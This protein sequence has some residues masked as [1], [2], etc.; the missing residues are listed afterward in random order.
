VT[1]KNGSLSCPTAPRALRLNHQCLAHYTE[2]YMPSTSSRRA[3]LSQDIRMTQ[4]TCYAE[5]TGDRTHSSGLKW[6]TTTPWV[7]CPAQK[8]MPK[9]TDRNKESSCPNLCGHQQQWAGTANKS[10]ALHR[11]LLR[12]PQLNGQPLHDA[13]EPYGN[14][15][16][17]VGTVTRLCTA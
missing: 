3:F 2:P 11:Q 4:F 10:A 1:D 9:A 15:D 16:R 8:L 12:L 5:S 6:N 14:R 13:T 7:I 17:S